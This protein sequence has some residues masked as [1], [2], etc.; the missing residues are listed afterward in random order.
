MTIEVKVAVMVFQRV[1]NNV[2]PFAIVACRPQGNNET[3][4][5]TNNM[6]DPDYEVEKMIDSCTFTSFARYSVPLEYLDIVISSENFLRGNT[7]Y[8]AGTDVR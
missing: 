4:N 6:C 2:S 5:F 3:G 1:P 8:N 7:N